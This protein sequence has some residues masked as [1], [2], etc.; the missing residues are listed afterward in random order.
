[1][2]VFQLGGASLLA[3]VAV[4]ASFSAQAADS[5]PVEQYHYGQKL[6]VKRV[7]DIQ[8]EK[9]TLL[10]GGTVNVRMNYLDSKGKR[11]TLAYLKIAS[12][13]NEGS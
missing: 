13:Y 8:E 10:S 11:H 12:G 2:N 3:V 1:M 6:D 4:I 5:Q 7:I 9:P